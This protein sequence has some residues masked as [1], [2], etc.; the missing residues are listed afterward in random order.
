MNKRKL[1]SLY[2]SN[3]EDKQSIANIACMLLTM[4]FGADKREDKWLPTS[5]L[6]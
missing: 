1:K 5:H 2:R 6:S 3:L 4:A